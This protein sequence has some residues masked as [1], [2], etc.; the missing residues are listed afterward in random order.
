MSF[1]LTCVLTLRSS[2]NAV[3]VEVCPEK[4]GF[5]LEKKSLL[6]T[7][8]RWEPP[9]LCW[10]PWVTQG[11]ELWFPAPS[12]ESKGEESRSLFQVLCSPCPVLGGV[13]LIFTSILHLMKLKLCLGRS[14]ELYFSLPD[15]CFDLNTLPQLPWDRDLFYRTQRGRTSPLVAS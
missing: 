10:V 7:T 11:R 9:G 6:E 4:S 3:A 13:L 12:R 2:R 1:H 14:L 5:A 15:R 8:L